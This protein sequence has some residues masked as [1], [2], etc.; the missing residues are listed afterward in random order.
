MR[1][2]RVWWLA[3]AIVASAY[4]F[5]PVGGTIWSA[6]QVTGLAMGHGEQRRVLQNYKGGGR[7]AEG[8][9]SAARAN[10][11]RRIGLLIPG[12]RCSSMDLQFQTAD[13]WVETHLSC[14]SGF[15]FDTLPPDR[16]Q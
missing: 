7:I 14:V 12:V 10:R 2:R 16:W 1:K 11:F 8:A 3:V 6:D 15:T 4:F 13:G 5:Y 9:L